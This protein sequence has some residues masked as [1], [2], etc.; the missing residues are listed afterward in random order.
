MIFKRK[1]SLRLIVILFFIGTLLI[2]LPKPQLL[3]YQKFDV[4][5]TSIYW[6]GF[7]NFP[8]AL[9]D[10]HLVLKGDIEQGKI[11]LCDKVNKNIG[12]Q[13]YQIVEQQGV[14]DVILFSLSH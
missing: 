12:C 10:S 13:K 14:F 8:A 7:L 11:F 9:L 4:V 1:T 2:L 3:S 6:P 5:G